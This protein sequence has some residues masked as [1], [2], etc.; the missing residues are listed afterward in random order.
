MT[1]TKVLNVL[2]FAKY[3]GKLKLR[4]QVIKEKWVTPMSITVNVN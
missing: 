3:V 2:W 1:I 4:T